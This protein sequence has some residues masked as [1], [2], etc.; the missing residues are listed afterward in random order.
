M[1]R[2]DVI[3]PCY[4]YGRYLQDCV[5]SVLS[6][7]GCDARILIIDDRSSDDSLATARALASRDAR[8]EVLAHPVNLGLNATINDGIDWAC[9]PYMLVLS[10]DD[11]AAP[12]AFARAIAL[13]EEN[14][15]ISF[16]HGSSQFFSDHTAITAMPL[17]GPS[18]THVQSG[19]IYIRK[20]CIYPSCPVESATAIVRTRCQKKVGHYRASLPHAGD[21]D[22]WLRLAAV[23]DVGFVEN[24]QAFSRMHGSNMR[25]TYMRGLALDDIHYRMQ[26]FDLFFAEHAASIPDASR[27]KAVN[28]RHLAV[29]TI[30]LANQALVRDPTTDVGPSLALV[31]DLVPGLWRYPLIFLFHARRLA[32]P[33]LWDM[34]KRT[35]DA[36]RR[37]VATS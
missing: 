13:M 8:I 14:A 17:V 30:G 4:N 21:Q 9:A 12:G 10:A 6:Q 36:W 35:R 24:C 2:I 11:L 20:Q 7:E 33:R 19:A 5:S 25:F 3:V 31:R 34:A 22:M 1:S 18:R 32:G 29:Q 37:S 15:A 23:G 26:V 28:R 27:L 16:V